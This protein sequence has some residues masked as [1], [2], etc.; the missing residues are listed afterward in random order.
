MKKKQVRSNK[1]PKK[2]RVGSPK[3]KRSHR[4]NKPNLKRRKSLFN[5]LIS[6]MKI[7]PIVS[8]SKNSNI[9]RIFR[10]EFFQSK[11]KMLKFSSSALA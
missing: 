10:K 5:T 4:I 3:K 2:K 6:R 8:R 7:M 9:S 11:E 1:S